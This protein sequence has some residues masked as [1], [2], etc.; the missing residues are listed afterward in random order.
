MQL[1]CCRR[2]Q[3]VDYTQLFYPLL[4]NGQNYEGNNFCFFAD[5]FQT[6]IIKPE[7]LFQQNT[8]SEVGVTTCTQD[9]LHTSLILKIKLLSTNISDAKL[10]DLQPKHGTHTL[11][12]LEHRTDS[13]THDLTTATAKGPYG[14]QALSCRVTVPR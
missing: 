6:T 1:A 2:L 14:S 7:N 4:Y 3:L 8:P 11:Y 10:P 9:E 5:L 13:N 12:L